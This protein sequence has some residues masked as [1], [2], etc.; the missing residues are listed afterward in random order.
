M[1]NHS[2]IN[3]MY[4]KI[5]IKFLHAHIPLHSIFSISLSLR[6]IMC[7]CQDYE[8]LLNILIAEASW[9]YMIRLCNNPCMHIPSHVIFS[10]SLSLR[11]VKCIWQDCAITHPC[12]HIYP[13]ISS[14]QYL[15]LVVVEGKMVQ[16]MLFV[17]SY[18]DD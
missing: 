12:M 17:D 16:H 13:R 5:A 11:Q 7:I 9:V 15:E 8:Y 14:S 1:S 2:I 4:V 10:M 3:S 18:G 6:Q